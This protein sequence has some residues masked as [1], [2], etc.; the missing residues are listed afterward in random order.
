M[1]GDLGRAARLFRKRKYPE[2]IRILEPQIFRFRESFQFYTLLGLSCLE[3]GDLSGA[4][5][6]LRRANQL[7][8]QDVGSLLALAAIHL[9]RHELTQAIER[10]LAVQDIDPGNRHARRG[11]E[12]AKR[13]AAEVQLAKAL[14]STSL[15]RFV[16]GPHPAER[17]L[18]LAAVVV[19]VAAIGIFVVPLAV[20][21][22]LVPAEPARSGLQAATLESSI[23]LVQSGGQARYV[24][25]VSEIRSTFNQMRDDFS[26]YRDNLAQRDINRLLG[27][28]ASEV[29]K[30]KARALQ[31]FLNQP[32]FSTMRDSFSYQEVAK[33]PFLYRNCYVDWKG[34]V[35][36]LKISR[37][38]ITFDFLVGYN[39]QKVLQGIVPV[40]LDFAADIRSSMP[41][42]LIGQIK[43]TTGQI[44]LRGVSV[45]QLMPV[46]SS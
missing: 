18:P 5:S 32:N 11:L 31:S 27:S 17:F 15:R 16:P 29:V 34:M 2:V 33:D 26:H 19:L 24:L 41:L 28:N 8:E 45:H 20:T 9:R 25:T 39:E 21:R 42:E 14:E 35:S 37:K 44:E 46:G 38:E 13:N 30:E 3:T 1:R 22:L 10:W 4:D 7:N 40:T 43:A 12:F 23:K 36:N 6:Y